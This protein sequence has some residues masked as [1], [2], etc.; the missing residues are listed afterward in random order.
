MEPPQQSPG[1]VSSLAVAVLCSGETF[2]HLCQ[3][4]VPLFCPLEFSGNAALLLSP[5]HL[6]WGEK[7]ALPQPLLRQGVFGP[8]PQ[9]PVS[10]VPL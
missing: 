1:T 10:T 9:T 2:G 8:E 3:L 4:R 5:A 6:L 7:G